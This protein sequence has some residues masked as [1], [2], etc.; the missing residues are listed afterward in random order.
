MVPTAALIA[1]GML[2]MVTAHAQSYQRTAPQN[3]MSQ[4]RRPAAHYSSKDISSYAKAA[5]GI[6]KVRRKYGAKLATAK[7][8]AEQKAVRAKAMSKM[9]KVIK[10]NGLSVQKYNQIYLTAMRDPGVAQRIKKDMAGAQ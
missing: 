7:T 3:E 8:P 5:N 2:G 9:V 4:N 1:I 6:E 10:S